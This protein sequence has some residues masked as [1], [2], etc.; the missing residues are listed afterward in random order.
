MERLLADYEPCLRFQR[1]RG[2]TTTRRY[3]GFIRDFATFVGN[4]HD[5]AEVGKVELVAFLRQAADGRA[6]PSRALWNL[7]LAALRSFFDYLLKGRVVHANP[8]LRVD[9]QKTAV[10]DTVPL[11]IDEL[12][13]VEDAAEA[14]RA[15]L[16]ERNVAI[17]E[18]LFNCALRVAEVVALDVDQV[19]LQNHLLVNVRVKGWKFLTVPINDL[20]AGAIEAYLAVREAPPGESALFLSSRRRRLSTRSVQELVR[21]LGRRAEIG[22]PVTPDLLRHSSATESHR[23]GGA[24]DAVARRAF[25]LRAQPAHDDAAIH[26]RA[27]PGP[28]GRGHSARRGRQD[29]ARGA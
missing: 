8:A 12:L 3:L 16:R 29:Q 22:R 11:S 7:R 13:S 17:V 21:A 2:R 27:R 15:R 14:T 20:A 23:D 28:A 9:R 5:L 18:L 10:K 26:P 19:D 1:M 6:E 4:G 24:W 25:H